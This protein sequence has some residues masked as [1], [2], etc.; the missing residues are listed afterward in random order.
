MKCHVLTGKYTDTFD[1]YTY[2]TPQTR[3]RQDCLVLS[4]PCLRCD[5]VHYTGS[6]NNI[7]TRICEWQSET[8]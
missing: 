1:L 3:T 5:T 8:C 6:G 7:V 2:F 4:C